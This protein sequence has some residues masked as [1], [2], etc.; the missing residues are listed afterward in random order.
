MAEAGSRLFGVLADFRKAQGSHDDERDQGDQAGNCTHHV[1]VHDVEHEVQRRADRVRSE[2]AVH[3]GQGVGQQQRNAHGDTH[4]DQGDL[5]GLADDVKH[6]TLLVA[7]GVLAGSDGGDAV[8]DVI[9]RAQRV[10]CAGDLI[11]DLS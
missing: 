10:S 9:G 4:T 11:L 3:S 1:P 5:E 2:P 8:D 7:L 6:E